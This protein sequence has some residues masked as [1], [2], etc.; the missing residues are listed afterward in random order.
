M[1]PVVALTVICTGQ[2]EPRT[3]TTRPLSPGPVLSAAPTAIEAETPARHGQRP[4]AQSPST[5]RLIPAVRRPA[6]R[7]PRRLA[8]TVPGRRRRPPRSLG[9]PRRRPCRRRRPPAMPP[10]HRRRRAPPRPPPSKFALKWYEIVGKGEDAHWLGHVVS[11]RSYGH[12]I[13]AGRRQWRRAHGHHH[14]QGMV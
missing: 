10:P 8:A 12:G 5:A 4:V 7:R 1:P 14:A 6:R 13:G 3:P 11:P 9:S 2:G